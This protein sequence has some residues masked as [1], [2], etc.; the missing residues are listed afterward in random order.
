MASYPELQLANSDFMESLQDHVSHHA[1]FRGQGKDHFQ[2]DGGEKIHLILL[3][4]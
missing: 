2:D 4:R 3:F 1:F